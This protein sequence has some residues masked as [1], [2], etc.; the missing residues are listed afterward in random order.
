MGADIH[1]LYEVHKT[2]PHFYDDTSQPPLQ[3]WEVA[4]QPSNLR[5]YYWFAAL[6]GVRNYHN[7]PVAPVTPLITSYI[8]LGYHNLWDLRL[9]EASHALLEYNDDLH[10][11]GMLTLQQA[12]DFSPTLYA[13][14]SSQDGLPGFTE[15]WDIMLLE[16][17]HIATQHAVSPSEVRIIFGFDS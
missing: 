8:G 4:G 14:A 6:A 10:S 9:S 1:A 2:Y 13:W 15:Q 3:K 16:M 7:C 17:R 12:E 5:N 11:I